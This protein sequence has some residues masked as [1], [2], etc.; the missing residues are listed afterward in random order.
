LIVYSARL[1]TPA[2]RTDLAEAA[3]AEH[4]EEIEVCGT[5]EVLLGDSVDSSWRRGSAPL[6]QLMSAHLSLASRLHTPPPRH[7]AAVS[8]QRFTQ[9]AQ[10]T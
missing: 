6:S 5:N 8:K 1:I 4:D 10:L 2:E 9:H 7:H 3:F